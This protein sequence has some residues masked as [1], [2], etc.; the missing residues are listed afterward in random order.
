MIHKPFLLAANWKMNPPT[1]QEAERL[2]KTIQEGVK[3]MKKRDFDEILELVICP[4]SIYLGKFRKNRIWKWGIQNVHWDIRGPHTGEVSTRMAED[5]DCQYAILGHSERRM[6][7]GESDVMINQKLKAVLRG[8]MV[9]IVCVG[10]NK[11][12]RDEGRTTKVISE[13]LKTIFQGVSILTLPKVVVAYEPIWAISS[14]QTGDKTEADNPNNV[15]GIAIL[16][17][18]VLTSMYRHEI[19]QRVRIIYGGSVNPKNI[20]GFLEIDTLDGAL[21]GGASIRT[22]D[23]LPLIRKI[24]EYKT[25][26]NHID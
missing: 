22:L 16:I 26:V 15:M 11:K 2:S 10:E 21:V 5:F 24:Y 9:P 17:K 1:F 7:F 12:E 20:E 19:V 13:Q 23:F 3:R 8:K 18:K 25:T 14:M 4:P 6:N